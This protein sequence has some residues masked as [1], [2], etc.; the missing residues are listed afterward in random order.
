MLTIRAIATALPDRSIV[1]VGPT[2]DERSAL[3]TVVAGG[4]GYLAWD[5][6]EDTLVE[7]LQSAVCGELGLRG[8]V[9]R[10]VVLLWCCAAVAADGSLGSRPSGIQRSEGCVA[11]KLR[12]RCAFADAMVYKY[13]QHILEKLRVRNRTQALALR[14]LVVLPN[15]A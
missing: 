6:G 14:V 13:I 4:D 3:A 7:T 8:R 11:A 2:A 15:V 5:D 1:A 12:R 10:T 9:A